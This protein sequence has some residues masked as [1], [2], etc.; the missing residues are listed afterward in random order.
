MDTAF[1]CVSSE[2][3][4]PAAVGLVNSLRLVGHD[5]P[6]FLL[7]CGLT[8]EHRAL[9]EP[10][11]TVVD[12]PGDTPPYLLKTVAPR[13]HPARLRVLIDVDVVVTRSL[14]PLFGDLAHAAAFAVK[15]RLDRFV[16]E[17]GEL[18]DLGELRRAP[19]VSSGFV[20]F[21]GADGAELLDLWDDRLERVDYGRSYFARDVAGYPFRYIDQDVLNAVIAARVEPD[22][23]VVIDPALFP[24]PPF[25]DLR[26]ADE[27]SLRTVYANGDEPFAVHQFVRKPW[28]EPM[29]HS[30]Y[31]RLLARLLL[32]DDVAI[33]MAPD[34]VPRRMKRGLRALVA[35]RGTDAADLARWYARDVIPEWIAERRAR[36]SGERP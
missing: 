14:R 15:D 36:R 12:A 32:G 8:P 21:A 3:Y 28:L 23:A 29:Y 18:L 13:L 26:V 5:E 9:L 1:Y 34:E 24:T 30:V 22:R 4:F 31:S 11:V 17:W 6:I 19:Y 35:R 10:E 16:P 2:V 7:D 33:R 20:G 27:S 25:R